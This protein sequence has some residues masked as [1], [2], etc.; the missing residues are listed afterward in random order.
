MNIQLS[1]KERMLLEEQK[2]HEEL[3][4][5][6]YKNYACQ[7]QDPQLKQLFIDFAVAEQSH[8][9][10][11]NQLL[12]GQI[13]EVG[14]GQ[15]GQQTP[16]AQQQMQLQEKR[17][18]QLQQQ[19]QNQ[20]QNQQNMGIGLDKAQTQQVCQDM[21][22][23]EKYISGTYDVTIFEFANPNARDVLNHIQKEEQQHGEGLYNYMSSH[24]MYNRK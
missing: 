5:E 23:T 14:Q 3:C 20:N 1:Q 7:V 10:S 4:I 9:D 15:Q 13:P 18:Q 22:S 8:L 11:I 12:A 6:K 2:A 16:Q 24:G 19:I 17:R 21:L